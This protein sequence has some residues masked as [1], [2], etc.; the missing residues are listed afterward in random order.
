MNMNEIENMINEI[1]KAVIGKDEVI[2]KIVMTLLARGHVLLEDIPGVGKT[3]LALALSKSVQLDYHRIQLTTDVMPSDIVGF[4]MYNPQKNIFEYKPGIALCH[5]LLADEINRTSSKT[6][7]ALLELMEEGRMT[8]DGTTYELPQP[9]FVIATQNPFGSAGTQLLPDSQLDRFMTRLSLGYPSVNDEVAI[10]KTRQIINPLESV[11]AILSPEDILKFQK[12]ID[13]I[14][15][16]DEIYYYIAALIDATRH[17]ELIA[18]GASPRGSLALMK[19]SKANAFM[20]GRDYVIPDDVKAVAIMT[21]AHRLILNYDA[22][23]K[24]TSAEAIIT[25]ILERIPTPG[26]H[27]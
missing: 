19:L 5:L 1:K 18:Q 9:F 26:I 27:L 22:K 14:F 20:H 8:V 17:H 10:M 11:Q 6:Q 15:I 23:I 4:T 25:D 3:N 24:E 7:A 16:S 12:E 2:E 21:L 13:Q